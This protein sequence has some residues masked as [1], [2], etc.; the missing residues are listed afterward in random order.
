MS[1]CKIIS[2]HKKNKNPNHN[3]NN[4]NFLPNHRVFTHHKQYESKRKGI[5]LCSW[6][7][8]SYTLE[9]AVVFP[10]IAG[11][12]VSL[13]FFIRVMQ[14]ETQVQ[15][16]LVYA[17]RMTA[18]ES[19]AVDNSAGELAT[20]EALFLKNI[21]KCN[22]V[23]KYVKGK[24]A[25]ISLLSSDVSGNDISLTANYFIKVPINLFTVTGIKIEQ[26]SDS[27][28]WTGEN[29]KENEDDPYV[30]YTDT[31]SVYHVTDKCRYLDLT[32][33]AVRYSDLKNLRN[34]S[35]GKYKLCPRCLKSYSNETKIVYI[36]D[37]GTLA[38]GSLSCS[39]L[40]RTVHMVH[41]SEVKGMRECSKCGSKL[42][43]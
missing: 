28:K 13:I 2:N 24:S 36:T 21:K 1:L 18:V 8:A 35:G 40:K 19:V 16:S 3:T 26:H 5:S 10:F 9:A 11:L 38:H 22:T 41:L 4:Y 7:K 29:V 33:R 37:Y 42:G 17:S 30:Y 14:I 32:I 6:I 23:K 20:A 27:R 39:S 15:A 43:E 12:M 25:G 34:K 31:G